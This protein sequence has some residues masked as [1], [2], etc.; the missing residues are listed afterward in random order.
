MSSSR[1]SQE[2]DEDARPVTSPSTRFR[3]R[4]T[5]SAMTLLIAVGGISTILL[6]LLVVVVLLSTSLPLLSPT[7]LRVAKSESL[8][9]CICFGTDDQELIVWSLDSSGRIRAWEIGAEVELEVPGVK[10]AETE[11]A[12]T[13][14][15]TVTAHFWDATNGFLAVGFSDGT[16][17]WTEV[18]FTESTVEKNV[19]SGAA[20]VFSGRD[21]ELRKVQLE[22]IEWSQAI[23]VGAGPVQRMEWL[24][25]AG[26]KGLFGQQADT[27]LITHGPERNGV[28]EAFQIQRQSMLS[29]EPQVVSRAKLPVRWRDRPGP[30]ETML[31]EQGDQALVVWPNGYVD[32][33]QQ[34]AAGWSLSESQMVTSLVR[35]SGTV[36]A[37]CPEF[38]R[39][40]IALG[41][42]DGRFVNWTISAYEP[43]EETELAVAAVEDMGLQ[44]GEPRYALAMNH[45]I[46]V[47]SNPLVSVTQFAGSMYFTLD[48]RGTVSAVNPLAEKELAR[49]DL[50]ERSVTSDA[51]VRVEA[52]LSNVATMQV[53]RRLD[54][55][56][57]HDG[58]NLV[59]FEIVPGG[60]EAT[61]KT[62]LGRTWYQGYSEPSYVWQ[63]ASTLIGSEPKISLIPLF[64]G[65]VKATLFAL[66]FSGPVGVLSAIYASEYLSERTRQR[67]RALFQIMSSLPGVVI[68]FIVATAIGPR[69]EGWL[70]EILFACFLIPFGF[71]LVGRWWSAVASRKSERIGESWRFV[72]G[73]LLAALWIAVSCMVADF[74]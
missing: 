61:P 28:M 39:Q 15:T 64:F 72:G 4:W 1:K 60:Y 21:D 31:T 10:A 48:S 34:S 41:L 30:I 59:A 36:T 22:S 45:S 44:W 40:G 62:I 47:T 74:V 33:F 35:E 12:I 17:R 43:A 29:N 27:V 19:A 51:G 18:R 46:S 6:L 25:A 26:Q 65:S 68:G 23:S 5:D 63:S 13:N 9:D 32:R 3:V 42:S 58:R 73:G 66:L 69:V 70:A 67:L 14:E 49:A 2:I 37:A 52:G 53:S 16:I 24:S 56:W 57:V 71:Y 8:P 20:V 7:E 38:N 54:H 55:I 11:T 50:L